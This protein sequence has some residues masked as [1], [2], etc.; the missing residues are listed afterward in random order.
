[1]KKPHKIFLALVVALGLYS[2]S[3]F[4]SNNGDKPKFPVP[5]DGG[6][7]ALI[8]AGVAYGAKKYRDYRMSKRE[9][10]GKTSE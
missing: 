5:I 10:D 7:S 4:G 3:V 8:V 9:E 2:P 1:M 6:V